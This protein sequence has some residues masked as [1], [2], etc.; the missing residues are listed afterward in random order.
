[1]PRPPYRI[2]F[3]FAFILMIALLT[4][5]TSIWDRAPAFTRPIFAVAKRLR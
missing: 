4:V 5:A 3:V 1:M 2:D